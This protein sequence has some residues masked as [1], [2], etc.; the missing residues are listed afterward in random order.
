MNA[1][2]DDALKLDYL[3]GLLSKDERARVEEH[4][5]G[6]PDCRR[7]LRNLQVIRASLAD[8][9]RPAVPDAWVVT[10]KA[11][12]KEETSAFD[13]RATASPAPVRSGAKIFQYIL[14]AAGVT[15][16]TSFFVWLVM[17]GTIQHWLP[18]LSTTAPGI[19][20]PRTA[21]T[22]DIVVLIVSLHSLLFIPSI[23]DNLCQLIRRRGRKVSRETSIGF[24]LC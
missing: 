5:A 6:C 4:L 1:C 12:L 8:L 20:N 21:R 24:S 23:I 2:M 16:A 9:P 19:A 11:R 3:N 15:A 22:V 14:V 10:A 17:S 7:E 13:F 18:G